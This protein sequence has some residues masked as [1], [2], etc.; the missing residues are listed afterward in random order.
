MIIDKSNEREGSF[1]FDETKQYLITVG[2]LIP[3]K[4]F[5]DVFQAL[6]ML[7]DNIELIMLG[8]GE[9]LDQLRI[10]AEALNLSSR[11]HFLGQIQNPFFYIAN[12]DVLVS[13]SSVEGF[14]N[15]LVEAMICRTAVISTD[16]ISGPREILAPSTNH[17]YQLKEGIEEA[18]FGL[19]YV[20][21]DVEGLKNSIRLL[22]N[23]NVLRESYEDKAFNQSKSLSIKKISKIYEEAYFQ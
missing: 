15:V 17:S 3:L 7:E 20:V 9:C 23:D 12:S 19:L 4:R 21:G 18:E 2:R 22:L 6:S 1:V 5:E 14:P 16:C 8:E 13:S 11:I 10:L